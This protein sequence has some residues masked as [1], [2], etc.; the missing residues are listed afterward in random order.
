MASL[1]AHYPKV[2]PGELAGSGELWG[3]ITQQ[4][5]ALGSSR[6]TPRPDA[7]L[8]TA[9][10]ALERREGGDEG[11]NRGSSAPPGSPGWEAPN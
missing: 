11:H 2:T 5:P 3:L 7:A 1:S 10:A 6:S 8:L 4:G 9:T